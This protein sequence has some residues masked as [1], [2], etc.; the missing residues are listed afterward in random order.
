MKFHVHT[1][2]WDGSYT[3]LTNYFPRA[4]RTFFGEFSIREAR[5]VVHQIGARGSDIAEF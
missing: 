5:V 3:N 4:S 1:Y 2:L